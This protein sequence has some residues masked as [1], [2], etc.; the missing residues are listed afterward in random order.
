M[1]TR[2]NR[3]RS[4]HCPCLSG[5]SKCVQRR[6]FWVQP[7]NMLVAA[8]CCKS[9]SFSSALLSLRGRVV[10]SSGSPSVL[11]PHQQIIILSISQ[12]IRTVRTCKL[13]KFRHITPHYIVVY[14][15]SNNQAEVWSFWTG[16]TE[17]ITFRSLAKNWMEMAGN[18]WSN[19]V[20][21]I[22]SWQK[23]HQTK[24]ECFLKKYEKIIR[25]SFWSFSFA[26]KYL[27]TILWTFFL[28]NIEFWYVK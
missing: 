11:L 5:H 8:Q 14:I 28:A 2:D 7:C 17:D 4:L 6:P 16:L 27:P 26:N 3:W 9:F 18:S 19:R 10:V 12:K 20:P 25:K 22:G 1:S 13:I 21:N 23:Y 15:L 24:T